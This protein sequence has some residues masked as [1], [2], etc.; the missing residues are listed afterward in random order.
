MSFYRYLTFQKS[1]DI[2]EELKR[3]KRLKKKPVP[4]SKEFQKTLESALLKKQKLFF[5]FKKVNKISFTVYQNPDSQVLES[6]ATLRRQLRS[7]KGTF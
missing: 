5:K 7:A 6:A 2:E 4:E 1:Q 3:Q